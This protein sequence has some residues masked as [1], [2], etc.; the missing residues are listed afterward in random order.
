[1]SAQG[2]LPAARTRLGVIVPALLVGA[3]TGFAGFV[4]GKRAAE[5]NRIVLRATPPEAQR[6]AL[7]RERPCDGGRCQTLWIGETS[8]DASE[9]LQLAGGERVEETAFSADGS[10]V[11]FLVNG[12]QLRVYESE[13]R[14]PRATVELFPPDKIPSSRIARGITFSPNGAAVTYDECPRYTSGCKSG[15]SAVR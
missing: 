10:L 15:L 2:A 9:V 4:S 11:G 1:M 3:L 14:L 7:V 6:V 5:A 12:Y 13:S 8:D